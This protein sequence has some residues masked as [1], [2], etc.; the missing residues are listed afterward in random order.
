MMST[1]MYCLWMVSIYVIKYFLLRE[2]PITA[3]ELPGLKGHRA[4]VESQEAFSHLVWHDGRVHF[5]L[6]LKKSTFCSI[7]GHPNQYILVD[8]MFDYRFHF[9]G[10]QEHIFKNIYEKYT[11]LVPGGG[12]LLGLK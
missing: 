11:F 1:W 12:V 2:S 10:L 6:F 9:F 4:S 8:T 7:N 3:L 5:R